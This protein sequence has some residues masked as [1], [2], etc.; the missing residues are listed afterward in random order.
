MK[1]S[2]SAVDYALLR[3]SSPAFTDDGMIPTKHACDGADTNPAL[4]IDGIPHMAKT[5]AIIVDDPD[6]PRGTWVHWVSW[7]IP[8]SGHIKENT[9]TGIEGLNDFGKHQYN[10]PCPP[11][12]IHH[13]HFKV[14]A[15]DEILNLPASTN[16]QALEHA[17]A[18][19]VLGFGELI[20]R[21]QR[22]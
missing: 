3:I 13:Y 18:G 11:S 21:Y 4:Q 15:L 14:Y 7:N 6:A 1:H 10:G 12:G 20:G 8:V 19:H 5:L 2:T 16:K 22:K 9:A 17:M